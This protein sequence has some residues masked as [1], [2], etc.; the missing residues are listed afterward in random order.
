MKGEISFETHAAVPKIKTP[1]LSDQLVMS[2]KAPS[3][4]IYRSLV[5]AMPALKDLFD[6]F[7]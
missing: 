1:L 5:G 3:V 4:D 6:Y 2:E 7:K